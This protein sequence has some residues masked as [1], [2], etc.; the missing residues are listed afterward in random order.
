MPPGERLSSN[1]ASPGHRD[2]MIRFPLG[3]PDCRCLPE[4]GPRGYDINTWREAVLKN[5]K[6]EGPLSS[7]GRKGVDYY[8][9][10]VIFPM[11]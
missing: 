7:V 6:T 10:L 2:C 9:K 5:S 3:H 1:W 11:M 8:N 4:G